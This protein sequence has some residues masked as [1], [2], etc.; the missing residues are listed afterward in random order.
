MKTRAIVNKRELTYMPGVFILLAFLNLFISACSQTSANVQSQP[1]PS[2][3]LSKDNSESPYFIVLSEEGDTEKLPLKSTSAEVNIAGVIADVTVKQSY[4]NM[5]DK[6]I[7]AIYVFPA[8]TRAAVYKMKMKINDREIEAIVKE[9]AEAR[10]MYETAKQE[11]KAASLLEQQRPNVFQMNVANIIP[12]AKVE[13]ELCYTELLV[14]VD[15]IYEFVYPTVVGPRYSNK[16]EE[17]TED[18]VKNPYLKEGDKPNY[19]FD[20]NIN[21]NAG[22]PIQQMSVPTHKTTINYT[23][24]KSAAIKL[25][26]EEA[27]SGNKDFILHYKLQGS[28][29]ETGMLVYEENGEKYFLAMLQP[30]QRVEPEAIPPREYVFIVDISG[31]MYGFPLDVSKEVMSN[32]LNNLRAKDRFNIVFF[33]GGSNVYSKKSLSATPENIKSAIKFLEGQ[34]GGGGTELLNALKTSFALEGT[35]DYS[36]TFVIHTDGYVS[37]EREAYEMVTENL[38][39][40]NVFAFGIGSSVNRYIIEGIAHAGKGEPFIVTSPDEAKQKADKFIEYISS[41]VLTNIDINY[42]G[43]NV[44]DVLP[45]SVPDIFAQ[46]PVILTGKFKGPANG[47]IKLTG[48]SGKGEFNSSLDFSKKNDNDN[49]KAL[50]YLWAREKIRE[51]SDYAKITYAQE[52][53]KS[54]V[55]L[56]LKYN[57]LTE[58][59]SFIAVDSEIM[60]KGGDQTTVNQPLPLPEGVSDY[61]VQYTPSASR[62]IAQ[63]SRGYYNAEPLEVTESYTFSDDDIEEEK[64]D[65]VFYVV[66][67]MPSFNYNNMTLQTYFDNNFKYPDEIKNKKIQ[68]RIVVEFEIDKDGSVTS[69]KILRGIDQKLDEEIVRFLEKMPKWKPGKQNGKPVKVKVTLPIKISIQ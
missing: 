23:N 28:S 46:R 54:I 61:A 8:S 51:L 9:K 43:I 1:L 58:Y 47:I 10:E 40:A 45:S 34:S 68:D 64:E 5:G 29:I 26:K 24:K 44:Y 4:S 36:R 42:S 11:G 63:K 3:K 20:I 7:E 56:G 31:S 53:K 49:L 30:P 35:E 22:M 32:L 55:E 2:E 38:D 69:V 65:Q 41:P 13:V 37:V 25:N 12:G 18:W 57:L 17:Q 59:T 19:S 52:M 39:E 21:I 27:Q 15:G 50:K 14:P 60:N 62:R 66:E 6:P 33:A 67:T 48:Q 16:T